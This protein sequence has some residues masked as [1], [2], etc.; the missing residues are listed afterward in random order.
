MDAWTTSRHS[1]IFAG[2]SSASASPSSI[3]RVPPRPKA[4]EPNEIARDR[5]ARCR[6]SWTRSYSWL[7][8]PGSTGDDGLETLRRLSAA[9]HELRSFSAGLAEWAPEETGAEV[10]PVPTVPFPQ[11]RVQTLGEP[12]QV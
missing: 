4:R 5:V 11:F 7:L 6:G 2:T 10:S 12:V 3:R 9:A 1:A 8:L